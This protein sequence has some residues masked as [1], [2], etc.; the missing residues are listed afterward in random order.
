M[1]VCLVK[2]CNNSARSK[3]HC[4]VHYTRLRRYGRLYRMRK[5]GDTCKIKNCRQKYYAK[6]YCRSHYEHFRYSKNLK[7]INKN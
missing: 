7:T 1:A 3:G 2:G 6:E 5:T 4:H